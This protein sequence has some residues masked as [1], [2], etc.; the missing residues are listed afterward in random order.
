MLRRLR[1]LKIS[2]ATKCQLL[3]GIA[4]GIIILAAL[5]VTWQRIEQLT[6]QQDSV[7]AETLAKQTL[8]MHAATGQLPPAM[9]AL[10]D[11]DGMSVRRPRLVGA[12]ES[13]DLTPFESRAL[14]RF[15]R[16]PGQSTH[17]ETYE[18][19]EGRQG[20]LL[21]MSVRYENRCT[22]CHS[23]PLASADLA[24]ITTRPVRLPQAPLVTGDVA[25]P[26][27]PER[28]GVLAPD[29]PEPVA[30]PGEQGGQE[31]ASDEGGGEEAAAAPQDAPLLGMVSV[32]IPSQIRARQRLLNR[33]FLISA[34]LAAA[35]TATITLYF[36]LT[37][38]ILYPM[39]V[40]QETAEKVRQGDLEVRSDIPSGDE[41]QT[42]SETFNE[43]LAGIQER[44]EQLRRANM[45]LDRKLGQ[46][47]ETNVALDESN[48][49][50]SEFLANVSHELRTPLN[51]IL[52]FADLLKDSS[53]DN[54][55]I[56]RYANNIHNSGSNLLELIND[57]LDLAKI[58]AGKM[59]IRQD[60][61]SLADMFEA[62]VT[63]LGPLAA[64]R[65]VAIDTRIIPHVPLLTTDPGKLQQILFNL[66]SN[67]I[68]FSPD[69]GRIEL[70]ARREDADHVRI[71]VRD[72]GPGIAPENQTRIFEKFRQLDGGVTRQHAGTGLGLAISRDLAN[73]LG[74]RL[75]VD[76]EPGEGATFWL[77]LPIELPSPPADAAR[78]LAQSATT[79]AVVQ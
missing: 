2:L 74:G 27:D 51:S 32:E 5:V 55:K 49:L 23:P 58:E 45:S 52:G 35:A 9:P 44:N 36:I 67:A 64:K 47:S 26:A 39:R 21:A 69:G 15:L 76:S 8:A 3:F 11:Y 43:M 79:T 48:R 40:L 60:S 62:L 17:R 38:L 75:G 14:A 50:K 10:D 59:E 20:H 29:E 28:P 31:A 18:T 42:L 6:R 34:S 1:R 63:L 19:E 4:A 33:V 65:R 13:A 57:L 68:K 54:P 77:I 46:L 53:R 12:T 56:V 37:R 30:Q 22:T 16:E 7:A 24:G 70:E 72:F 25:G 41:F 78:R 61:L 73:L 71:S 66:L